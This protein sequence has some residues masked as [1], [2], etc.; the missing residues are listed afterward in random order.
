M[1]I[2]FCILHHAVCPRKF[3]KNK[4]IVFLFSNCWYYRFHMLTYTIAFP[5]TCSIQAGLLTD[6]FC[7]FL[8]VIFSISL[9]AC[10]LQPLL[11]GW[12]SNPLSIAYF[13]FQPLPWI[14]LSFIFC[15]FITSLGLLCSVTKIEI[16][17]SNPDSICEH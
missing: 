5:Y 14:F 11:N 12:K 3:L 13:P 9:V 10:L 8:S 16:L 15:V 4:H 7:I 1:F 6:M 17:I 2:N